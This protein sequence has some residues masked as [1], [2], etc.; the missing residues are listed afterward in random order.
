MD[1]DNSRLW[2]EKITGPSLLVRAIADELW[3]GQS[4]LLRAPDDL[5]WRG[6]M[7]SCVEQA[8]REHDTALLV[9]YVD[10]RT[11]NVGEDVSGFLLERYATPELRNGYRSSSGKSKQAYILENQILYNRIVW[12]KGM[13]VKQVRSWLSFCRDYHSK[14]PAD[15][16]F[17]IEAYGLPDDLQPAGVRRLAFQDF[18][19]YYDAL[20]F[21][22]MQM[23]VRRVG[24]EWKQYISTLAS[25]LCG[26][27]AE[28]STS[29]IQEADLTRESAVDALCRIAQRP[30]YQNRFHAEELE[31]SHP[32]F[33]IRNGRMDEMTHK[34]W[35]A[36]LQTVF[37]LLEAERIGLV[38]CYSTEVSEGLTMRYWDFDRGVSRRLKQFGE[39]ITQ[40]EDAELGTLY[41]M[42]RL[43]KEIDKSQ[44]LLFLPVERDRDR[45]TLIYR[46]RNAIAHSEACS[47]EDIAAFLDGYPHQWGASW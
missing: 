20:L 3:L 39:A 4:V 38:E 14:K 33:L 41:R 11:D 40:A 27:D 1:A 26:W 24:L 16:L 13:T 15:G 17:V 9:D 6:R 25:L 35:Q 43:R 10:C 46:L 36:Q 30:C 34:V 45:L 19:S 31:E 37:P 22:N 21:N 42:S 8:L 5:P 32:F 23:S 44:H 29:L 12:V 7:R 2:W 28:L 18:V 47:V